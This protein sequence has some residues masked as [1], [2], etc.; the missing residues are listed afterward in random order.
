MHA[1]IDAEP[2][3]TY[4]YLSTAATIVVAIII[5]LVASLSEQERHTMLLTVAVVCV[6]RVVTIEAIRRKVT[7]VA[8]AERAID[9][10]WVADPA[11]DERPDLT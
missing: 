1:R 5:A 11:Q 3:R 2:V 6:I 4:G 10:A 7:P 8:T 9:R